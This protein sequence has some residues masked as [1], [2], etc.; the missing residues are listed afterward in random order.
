MRMQMFFGNRAVTKTQICRFSNEVML[1]FDWYLFDAA[2]DDDDDDEDDDGD[3]DG[4]DDDEYEYEYDDH[5]DH[6]DDD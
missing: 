1:C 6:D 2:H 4:D 5:D 3:D